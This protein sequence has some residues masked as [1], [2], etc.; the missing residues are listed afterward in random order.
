[1]LTSLQS[2]KNF[3][4]SVHFD[5]PALAEQIGPD[6][7]RVQMDSLSAKRS[8]IGRE[9]ADRLR[10]VAFDLPVIQERVLNHALDDLGY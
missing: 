7:L 1:M 10:R 8:D 2:L 3:Y 9:A 6:V 5:N 4:E